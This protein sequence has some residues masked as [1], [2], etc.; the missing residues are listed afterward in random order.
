MH[1]DICSRHCS[2]ADDVLNQGEVQCRLIQLDIYAHRDKCNA[3]S[4]TL[5][6]IA[7]A[8]CEIYRHTTPKLK[9]MM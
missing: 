3:D 6:V 1:C 9:C 7:C 8:L 2:A 5:T 4:L